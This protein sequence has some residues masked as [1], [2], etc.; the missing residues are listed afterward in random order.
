VT[1]ERRR[2]YEI[3]SRLLGGGLNPASVEHAVELMREGI[4]DILWRGKMEEQ[5]Q[6][7]TLH[8]T[9]ANGRQMGYARDG[10]GFRVFSRPDK[11]TEWAPGWIWESSWATLA[12]RI[13]Q[14]ARVSE[15]SDER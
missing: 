12:D 14:M 1:P 6:Q 5:Q 4:D 7:V 11:A 15:Q 9:F 3:A 8:R 10:N 2:A 13:D